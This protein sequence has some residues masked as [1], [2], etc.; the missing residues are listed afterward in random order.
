MVPGRS[1]NARMEMEHWTRYAS[2]IPITVGRDIIDVASGEGYGSH[3]MAQMSVSVRGIDLSHANISHALEKYAV[4]CPNLTYLQGDASSSIPAPD[5]SAD[6]VTSFETIE[7]LEHPK[8]LLSEIVRVMR[9]HGVAI[10]TTPRPNCDPKTGKPYNPHHFQEF[11]AAQFEA[12]LRPFFPEMIIIGQT[13]EFPFDLHRQYDSTLDNYMIAIAAFQRPALLGALVQFQSLEVA[14]LKVRLTR[15]HL[16][17]LRHQPRPPRVL[18]VP[19]VDPSCANPSDRRRIE[20]V[21]EGLRDLGWE[22][23][24]MPREEASRTYCDALFI[25]DRDWNFWNQHT[26]RLKKEGKSLILTISDLAGA[27]AQSKAHSESA[28]RGIATPVDRSEE[29]A[30]MERFLGSCDLILA[31][32]TVQAEHLSRIAAGHKLNIVTEYDP[33]DTTIYDT[34]APA[35]VR[36]SG[37]LRIVWEGFCDNVPYLATVGAALRS[38][39]KEFPLRLVVATSTRRR[40]EFMGTTDNFELAVKL[41][42][43]D[44]VEFHE[45]NPRTIAGIIRSCDIGI[46]PGFGDDLF[47]MAK[48]PNKA[49]IFNYFGIPVV[50]SPSQALHSWL[51]SSQSGLIANDDIGWENS[52]KALAQNRELA[53]NM[54]QNGRKAAHQF[55]PAISA[56]RIAGLLKSVI[57]IPG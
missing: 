2:I 8:G 15:R 6:V 21:S 38:L 48:P 24:I 17:S 27:D 50:A 44:L 55:L 11:D 40:T 30:S 35:I 1:W 43:S 18:F 47:S 49:I 33:I 7:H 46:V 56:E 39:A 54:G 28:F 29:R 19:L 42:G 16:A 9:P 36:N 10:I 31:G 22:A 5:Q 34:N 52:L 4:A 25:Q 14:S 37:Q 57:R 23:A 53:R 12:L 13:G 41:I 20:L 45:W 26:N 3:L 32:S 51:G